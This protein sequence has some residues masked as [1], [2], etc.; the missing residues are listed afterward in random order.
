MFTVDWHWIPRKI[1]ECIMQHPQQ[2]EDI[3]RFVLD[4]DEFEMK[5]KEM[6]HRHHHEMKKLYE[7]Y[8]VT[9]TS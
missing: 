8:W 6:E 3:I 7:E 4:D 1:S 9:F 5:K 2:A